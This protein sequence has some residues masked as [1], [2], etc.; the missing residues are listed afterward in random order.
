MEKPRPSMDG[1]RKNRTTAR[2]LMQRGGSPQYR[3]RLIEE[4]HQNISSENPSPNQITIWSEKELIG[5]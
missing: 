4:R 3:L 5:N 2:R 1:A